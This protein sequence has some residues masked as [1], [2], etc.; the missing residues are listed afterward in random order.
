MYMGIFI[1]GKV[2]LVLVKVTPVEEEL[3]PY[4]LKFAEIKKG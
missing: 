2:S 1:P 4:V 3:L